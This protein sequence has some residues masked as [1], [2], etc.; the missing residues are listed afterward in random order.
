MKA[1]YDTSSIACSRI[2]TK[3]YTTSFAVGIRLLG[4][5]IRDAVYSVYGFVRLADEIVDTFHGYDQERMLTDLRKD[6]IRAIDEK[7]ST[8]PILH[9]FQKAVHDYNIE[10]E[11]VDTFLTSMAMD[12]DQK[13][14]DRTSFDQYVLGSA[15]VVGLMC[16]RVFCQ[17]KP[18]L[19][20]QLKDS[21]KSLG[22]AFQKINFLRDMK[23]DTQGLG[24][25]YFPQLSNKSFD[26]DTKLQIEKE[27][28]MDFE[29]GYQGILQ[30]PK[31]SRFGVYMAYMYFFKL[32]KK[33]Q[34]ATAK[35]VMQSRIRISNDRKFLILMGSYLRHSMNILWQVN[36]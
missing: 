10:W 5:E 32:F 31:N 8:N 21:A 13:E 4:P 22:A 20:D 1:L 19:Y 6:T 16:L 33:I 30:L 25:N 18:G 36:K 29:H 28:A 34:R 7:I 3:N 35:D 17:N 23:A 11:L 15:E 24:R 2:V 14:H 27:I 9:A 26:L 12:L